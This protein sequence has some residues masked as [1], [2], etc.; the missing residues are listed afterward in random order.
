[1]P[2]IIEIAIGMKAVVMLNIAMESDL[3]NGTRGIVEDIAFDPHE[4]EPSPDEDNIVNLLYPPALILFCPSNVT[5]TPT[6]KGIPRGLLPIIPTEVSFPMK[7]KAAPTYTVHCH[8]IALTAGYSFTHHKVQGQT[9]EYLIVDLADS[10]K[11]ELD[12]FNAY[13][14]LSCSHGRKTIWIL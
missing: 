8:Q 10:P 1:M 13:I 11:H 4:P 14:A 2:D 9:L 3:E 12:G 7:K 6:F 5:K